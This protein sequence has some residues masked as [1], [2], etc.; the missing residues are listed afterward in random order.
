MTE[1]EP[2]ACG[3]PECHVLHADPANPI[4]PPWYRDSRLG[5]TPTQP[6][7]ATYTHGESTKM[8][9]GHRVPNAT[10]NKAQATHPATPPAAPM[11]D[12]ES[13]SVQALLKG[14]RK[15][16]KSDDT[17]WIDANIIR[18]LLSNYE[19]DVSEK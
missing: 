4:H 2:G 1:P 19:D 12:S 6:S 8:L 13:K 15:C 10:S 3:D 16:V 17:E 14:L 9:H 7:A 18:M 11:A 5:H